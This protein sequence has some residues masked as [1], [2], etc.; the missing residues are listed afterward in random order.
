[1][2]SSGPATVNVATW[3]THIAIATYSPACPETALELVLV[4]TPVRPATA[5][6]AW[7]S[8]TQ[9]SGVAE[10]RHHV[11]HA[12]EALALAAG[13]VPRRSASENERSEG[14]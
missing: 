5:N 13:M 10:W 3:S 9:P 12:C 6:A 8:L 2:A 7:A 1:M 14:M 4:L 11:H